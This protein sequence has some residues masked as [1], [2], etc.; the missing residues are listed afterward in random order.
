[1]RSGACKRMSAS[2]AGR[3]PPIARGGGATP[4]CMG[5]G[6]SHGAASSAGRSPG[7]ERRRQQH[8]H[9]QST[10]RDTP[11]GGW[12]GRARQRRAIWHPTTLRDDCI[13]ATS[14]GLSSS[15]R[16]RLNH[17]MQVSKAMAALAG[18]HGPKGNLPTP[19]R[20]LRP[21]NDWLPPP[22]GR[23]YLAW[24]ARG[25][26]RARSAQRGPAPARFTPASPC[27]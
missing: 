25:E 12:R 19:A 21:Y 2:A 15:R 5:S 1:M 9:R 16:S 24:R 20:C 6:A 17:T 13:A 3:S 18:A 22:A 8:S 26:P 14:A 27:L 11:A 10:S 4:T 7:G 23:G